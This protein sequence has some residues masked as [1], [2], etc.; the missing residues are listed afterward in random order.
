ML[1]PITLPRVVSF[2]YVLFATNAL[3]I[4]TTHQLKPN[5]SID[6]MSLGGACS[7]IPGTNFSVRCNPALFPYSKEE[8]V[9]I[10]IAG[11]ADGDSIDNGRDLIFEPIS[12]TLIRKLFEE[13]NFNSFTFNS[14]F[15]FKTSF[16]ELSY[17]PYYLLADIYIFN[18]AFP[19]ISL[20]MANRENL[21]F[22][23]GFTVGSMNFLTTEFTLTSGAGV[24]Y[25]E[26]A[27]ENT[28]FSLFDLTVENPEELIH[29]KTLYGVGADVGF[30][31]DN[32]SS[33]FPRLAMQIKN[34]NS[35]LKTA[36]TSS[37]PFL[38]T[39]QFL[40]ET[41]STVGIGKGIKTLYGGIDLSF[42]FPFYDYF[43]EVEMDHA[44]ISSRYNIS[45]F[46]VL[47]GYGK[48]YKNI[49]LRFD[50]KNFNVGISYAQESDMGHLQSSVEK[51]VY[52][53]IDIIL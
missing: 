36:D 9:L 47:L 48:F 32:N 42:E 18:P 4:V 40:F 51:S 2:C 23:S 53:G 19:E 39:T 34:M 26:H 46:S 43:G 8:G 14:D 45:L 31:L 28:V 30:F 17:A 49:G 25:Y 5:G 12:E 35:K 52:T 3:A 44:T 20:N 22:T 21:R 41:Y 33:F 29:I 11:K 27:Y 15:I 7:T 38:Q 6:T 50:S 24:Y 1:V 37:I 13:K 10:A 16:F